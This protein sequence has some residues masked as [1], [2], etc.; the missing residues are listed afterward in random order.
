[1]QGSELGLFTDFYTLLS[2]QHHDKLKILLGYHLACQQELFQ[3]TYALP[4]PYNER[5]SDIIVT[6]AQELIDKDQLTCSLP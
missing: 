4:L 6:E 5:L 1:M 2:T 3:K